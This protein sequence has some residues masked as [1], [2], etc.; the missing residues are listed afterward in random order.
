MNRIV[1]HECRHRFVVYIIVKQLEVAS[2]FVKKGN[3]ITL[4]YKT[5]DVNS[6]QNNFSTTH[7]FEILQSKLKVSPHRLV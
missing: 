1:K 7:S 5:F 3:K 6:N 4:G 2:F